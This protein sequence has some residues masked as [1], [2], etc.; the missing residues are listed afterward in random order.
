MSKLFGTETTIPEGFQEPG[1][2]PVATG[3][4]QGADPQSVPQSVP[5]AGYTP[6]TE[7]PL[8]GAQAGVPGT[9]PVA[10]YGQ[11]QQGQ[12]EVPQGNYT[13]SQEAPGASGY[14][15]M[16]TV[17]MEA[18]Q[19]ALDAREAA[20]AAKEAVLSQGNNQEAPKAPSFLDDVNP[21]TLESEGERALYSAVETLQKELQETR[22]QAERAQTEATNMRVEGEIHQT[23]Q[24]YGVTR[25]ELEAEYARSNGMVRDLETLAKSILFDRYQHQQAQYESQAYQ[26]QAQQAQQDRVQSARHIGGSP[27]SPGA[28]RVAPASGP[29]AQLNPF[30]G[31]E[32]AKHYKAFS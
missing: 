29:R 18:R 26:Q 4:V 19:S 1:V 16:D 2:P 31:A 20:I 10:D 15:P 24:A 22:S 6:S 17:A 11:G 13:E 8:A 21:E 23:M 25:S 30:D 9:V 7:Q 27:G 32:V 3:Q 14:S 5:D 12:Y 28:S